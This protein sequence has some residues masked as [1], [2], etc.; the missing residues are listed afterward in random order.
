MAYQIIRKGMRLTFRAVAGTR[1]RTI[2]R[3]TLGTTSGTS[4]RIIASRTIRACRCS[5]C[6]VTVCTGSTR[7]TDSIRVIERVVPI[8]VVHEKRHTQQGECQRYKHTLWR[9]I[10][11]HETAPS[12]GLSI[13]SVWSL[14]FV[15]PSGQAEQGSPSTVEMVSAG[16]M[17]Q[18]VW[19]ALG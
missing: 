3:R 18:A 10:F 1:T 12:Q 13:H 11:T 15:C 7:R 19:S 16:Q 17:R 2:A 4:C 5:C 6:L 8:A 9:F 14:L